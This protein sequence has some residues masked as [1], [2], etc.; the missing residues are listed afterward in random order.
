MVCAFVGP[1]YDF[2]EQ[3][4]GYACPKCQRE[5]SSGD[6]TCEIVGT[7]A[8]CPNCFEE[9]VVSPTTFAPDSG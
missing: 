9:M 5:I 1:S 8:Q 4:A 7:S 2:V 6:E 3:A